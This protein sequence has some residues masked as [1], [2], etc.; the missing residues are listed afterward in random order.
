LEA[1]KSESAT[2]VNFFSLAGFPVFLP[3]CEL[4]L[5]LLNPYLQ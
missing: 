1:D 4:R 2:E 3:D 5:A